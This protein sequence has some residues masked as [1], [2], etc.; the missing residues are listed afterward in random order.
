VHN[1]KSGPRGKAIQASGT[2]EGSD[3]VTHYAA[4]LTFD[5]SSNVYKVVNRDDVE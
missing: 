4:S 3:I 2:W 5:E 1:V